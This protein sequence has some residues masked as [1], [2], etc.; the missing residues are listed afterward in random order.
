MNEERV[1]K[2]GLNYT[3]TGKR[4]RGRP[5]KLWRSRTGRGGNDGDDVHKYLNVMQHIAYSPY[6][7]VYTTLTVRHFYQYTFPQ[8]IYG[9]TQPNSVNRFILIPR[10]SSASSGLSTH[11]SIYTSLSVVNLQV[12]F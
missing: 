2:Q 6:T 7:T 9:N 3:P 11:R 4:T 10:R 8:I 12:F 5:R 1:P